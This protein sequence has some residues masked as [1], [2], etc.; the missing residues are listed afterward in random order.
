MNS[1]MALTATDERLNNKNVPWYSVDVEKI[2][3]PARE[4]LEKYSQIPP[5][6]VTRHVFEVVR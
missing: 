2:N 6:Q 1:T 5:D 3:S 4:L